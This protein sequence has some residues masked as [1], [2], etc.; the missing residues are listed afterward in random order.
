MNA[1]SLVE[2]AHCPLELQVRPERSAAASCATG[3]PEGWSST[4]TD[5][6]EHTPI[7]L[8]PCSDA[9]GC[10]RKGSTRSSMLSPL[11]RARPD[12]GG[13]VL[14]GA[15]DAPSGGSTSTLG[16]RSARGEALER[17]TCREAC[18]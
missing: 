18:G 8:T 10:A 7:P 4:A 1:A 12:Q 6:D 9:A 14:A 13:H 5:H 15:L 2:Q 3:P 17:Y 16:A 11:V